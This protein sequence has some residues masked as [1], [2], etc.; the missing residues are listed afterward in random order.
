MDVDGYELQALRGAANILASDADWFVEVHVAAGLENEGG[1]WQEVLDFFPSDRY[2]RLISN[3]EWNEDYVPFSPSSHHLN[4]RF[5]M[6]AL[7]RT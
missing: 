4:S 2:E 7:R 3:S 6:V 5:F 1:T